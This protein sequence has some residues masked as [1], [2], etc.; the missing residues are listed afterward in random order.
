MPENNRP[1]IANDKYDFL[2]SVSRGVVTL[3]DP[4]KHGVW[5]IAVHEGKLVVRQT[6]E[7]IN[8]SP[9]IGSSQHDSAYCSQNAH[10]VRIEHPSREA[11]ECT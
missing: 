11:V 4:K 8:A 1:R 3:Y 6:N 5:E 10:S 7:S 2:Y 9:N